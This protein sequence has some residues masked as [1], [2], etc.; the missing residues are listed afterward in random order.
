M[1]FNKLSSLIVLVVASG[2]STAVYADGEKD[3]KPISVGLMDQFSVEFE[4]PVLSDKQYVADEESKNKVASASMNTKELE[5]DEKRLKQEQ[6]E[7]SK[8]QVAKTVEKLEEKVESVE[9]VVK[10]ETN[11]AVE[12]KAQEVSSK[13]KEFVVTDEMLNSSEVASLYPL[14]PMPKVEFKESVAIDTKSYANTYVVQAGI[15]MNRIVKDLLTDELK[16]K[17]ITRKMLILSIYRMNRSSFSKVVPIF[18]YVNS[19]LKIPTEKLMLLEKDSS[20]DEFF[21]KEGEDVRSKQLPMLG[22]NAPTQ[23]ELNKHEDAMNKYK[24]DV[25]NVMNQRREYL[26]KQ[27]SQGIK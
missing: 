19:E 5:E 20:F 21:S 23:E 7:K 13:V 26:I 8:Q 24:Q 9:A 16:A 12:Q 11:D 10:V 3:K 27:N 17:G 22:G 2:L 4:R 14:P 15:G 1:K 6:L 18:P 25:E